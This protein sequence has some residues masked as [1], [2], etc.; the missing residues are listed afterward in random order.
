MLELYFTDRGQWRSWLE[1]NYNKS[2]EVWLVYY[3]KHT[4][5][6][7]IGYND[8]VEEAICFG[9]IDSTVNKIDEEKYRQRYTPRHVKSIW[10]DTNVRRAEKMIKAGRMTEIGL[11]K[12]REGLEYNKKFMESGITSNKKI[13]I[14][15][16]LEKQ[17]KK[18]KKAWSNFNNFA[19][20]YKKMY[21][22]WY[23]DAIREDTR[24]RRMKEIVRR[25]ENNQR[26]ITQ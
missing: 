10:S 20:S 5:K 17:L 15:A 3:K 21:I 4:G 8:A 6:P 19:D 26:S 7:T 23:L 11:A 1:K 13:I 9:W 18:N 2:K 16:E 14:P 22:F 24:A 25:S 12:Y